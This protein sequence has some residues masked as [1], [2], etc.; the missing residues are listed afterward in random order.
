MLVIRQSRSNEIVVLFIADFLYISHLRLQAWDKGRPVE[1]DILAEGPG[2]R[3][4]HPRAT[5]SA[6]DE[7]EKVGVD[8]VERASCTCRAGIS[9]RP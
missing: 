4:R 8:H 1:D 7:G 6:L 5:G 3:S 2:R 9:H